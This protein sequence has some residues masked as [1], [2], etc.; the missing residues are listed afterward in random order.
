MKFCSLRTDR[1]AVVYLGWVVAVKHRVTGKVKMFP[2]SALPD[3][4]DLYVLS[5]RRFN[6]VAMTRFY[7]RG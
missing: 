6:I 7:G 5:Q 2:R 4:E 3:F 1:W